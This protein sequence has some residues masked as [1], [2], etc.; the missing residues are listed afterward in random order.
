M[1]NSNI[2]GYDLLNVIKKDPDN[3]KM[4]GIILT[5]MRDQLGISLISDEED[6]TVFPNVRFEDKPINP[7]LLVEIIR[8]MLK[9]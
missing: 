3:G 4:P 8:D 6:E 7:H 5:G 9:E 2:E 1:M